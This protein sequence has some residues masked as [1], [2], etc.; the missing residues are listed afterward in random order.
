MTKIKSLHYQIRKP[1]NTSLPATHAK[2][3]ET[4]FMLQRSLGTRRRSSL[5]DP[6]DGMAPEEVVVNGIPSYSPLSSLAS[7]DGPHDSR[8][9]MG[10]EGGLS[11]EYGTPQAER[12]FSTVYG[13]SQTREAVLQVLFRN[14]YFTI[15]VCNSV[16]LSFMFIPDEILTR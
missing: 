5:Q 4:C 2:P 15:I 10:A 9:C 13:T 6:L 16:L 11:V 8:D 3:H 12:R 7:S 14:I 1:Q